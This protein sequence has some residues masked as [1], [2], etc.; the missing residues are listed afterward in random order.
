LLRIFAP[1]SKA[2]LCVEPASNTTDC[3]NLLSETRERVGGCVLMPGEEIPGV[4][5]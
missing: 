2:L 4:L 3:F 5:K 1:A